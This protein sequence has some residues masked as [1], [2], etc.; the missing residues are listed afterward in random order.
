MCQYTHIQNYMYANNT[1]VH[2]VCQLLNPAFSFRVS[3]SSN[4]TQIKLLFKFDK[5]A[6]DFF[7]RVGF[8]LHESKD[9]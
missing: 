8:L 5:L 6:K 7:F 1:Y 9:L 3:Y 4:A 2:N